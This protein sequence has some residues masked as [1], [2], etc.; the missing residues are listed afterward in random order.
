MKGYNNMK[1]TNIQLNACRIGPH[2]ELLHRELGYGV[3][4]RNE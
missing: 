1:K 2:H 4:E 3:I